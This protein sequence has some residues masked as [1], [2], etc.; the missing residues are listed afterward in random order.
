MSI[1]FDNATGLCANKAKQQNERTDKK[2]GERKGKG[3]SSNRINKTKIKIERNI[4]IA[5][6]TLKY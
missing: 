6:Q 1:L 5:K 4:N 2:K 3:K